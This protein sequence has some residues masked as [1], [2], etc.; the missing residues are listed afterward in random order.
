[1]L[2]K[3]FKLY[4]SIY[5]NFIIMNIENNLPE[6]E[7]IYILYRMYIELIQCLKTHTTKF[8]QSV[9]KFKIPFTATGFI[10]D[11]YIFLNR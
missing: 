11:I 4:Q 10:T 1:M 5:N 3:M 9:K 6:D 8:F 2:L 7:W